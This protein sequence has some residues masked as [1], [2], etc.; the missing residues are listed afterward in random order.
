[1]ALSRK[2]SVELVVNREKVDLPK[3]FDLNLN[4]RIFNPEDILT[5]NS[6]Y[7]YTF[8]LPM[9]PNNCKI[10]GYANVLSVPSKFVKTYNAEL[11]AD[12]LNV[13]SGKL[14]I[15]EITRGQFHCNLV[16]VK[17][18]TISDIFGDATLNMIDWKVDFNG[19]STI[20]QVN[21]DASTK[22]WFPLVCYGAFAKKPLAEYETY[23]SYSSIYSI[24]YTNK[25]YYSSFYPSLN[26]ME[27]LK[28]CFE[29]KGYQLE[30][31]ALSNEYLNNIYMS[32][33]LDNGQVPIYNLGNPRFGKVKLHSDF[34]NWYQYRRRARESSEMSYFAI[35]LTGEIIS[36][37]YPY[38]QYNDSEYNFDEVCSYNMLNVPSAQTTYNSRTSQYDVQGDVTIIG[39]TFLYALEDGY[40]TIPSDGLYKIELDVTMQL[41]TGSTTVYSSHTATYS[42]G[43]SMKVRQ[44]YNTGST[45]DIDITMTNGANLREYKPIEVQLVRNYDETIELIK[46]NVSYYHRMGYAPTINN[47][48]TNITAYPHE[49]ILSNAN[50]PTTRIDGSNPTGVAYMPKYNASA[51]YGVSNSELFLYDPMVNPNFICGFSTI[52]N[53]ASIIKDGYSWYKGDTTKNDALYDCNGY[54]KYD[55]TGESSSTATTDYHKN[56]SLGAPI[57]SNTTTEN[58][59]TFTGHIRMM[60]Y[61]NK[62]DRLSLRAITRHYDECYDDTGIG[63]NNWKSSTY[64]I[65]VSSDLTIEAM[66]PNHSVKYIANNRNYNTP[67][68]FGDKLSLGNFLNSATTMA[69]FVNDI[70]K[71]F[72]LSFTQNGNI[73][74]LDTQKENEMNK[75]VYAVN[76]DDRVRA[77][78]T[79]SSFSLSRI[80]YPSS[81]AVKYSIN[82]SE[83]GFYNTVPSEHINDDDWEDWGEKGYDIIKLDDTGEE[84]AKEE[85]IK[86]SYT[87]YENF[88][89]NHP[90]YSSYTGDDGTTY[91]YIV[92]SAVTSTDISIPVIAESQYF[93]DRGDV[94]SYMLK[95]GYSLNPRFWF[96]TN[97]I[98]DSANTVYNISGETDVNF[99]LPSNNYKEMELNYKDRQS[100]ILSN[101]FNLSQSV[102]SQYVEVECYLTAEEYFHLKNGANI[103][104]DSDV[105]K[106][107]EI[108]KY[109]V[110]RRNPATIK[111]M[112]K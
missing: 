12:G 110:T 88:T 5:K 27:V 64:P 35:P 16:I 67:S 59:S 11:N 69:D 89:V 36:L 106:V 15:N 70:A 97:Y 86:E 32:T 62:D 18:N 24:D 82:T 81:L 42:N 74:T 94:E 112:K 65:S 54:V 76:I 96:R 75:G 9:T 72:N 109:S 57:V 1:M 14:R 26:M 56:S 83:A 80:E 92:N 95:D 53:C 66:S 48:E 38:D 78:S 8:T 107:V 105:Y 102:E 28:K 98:A 41:L 90:Q 22:Y 49:E 2:Y 108:G 19:I 52:G 91:K 58:G 63:R 23:N 44:Y 10:F 21:A 13:F 30:G 3:D 60:V 99:Y 17:V 77:F 93:I 6:E 25:F 55:T 68:E 37:N 45:T 84:N 39:D 40:V 20:N 104:F 46:G 4:T 33:N 61:L 103:I 87:W 31:T 79:N 51:N 47:T 111:M 100:N 50:Y 71:A 43:T 29:Y 85:S 7:S 34:K 73:C 101:F